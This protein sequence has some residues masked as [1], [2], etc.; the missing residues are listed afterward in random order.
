MKKTVV[1]VI[2]LLAA[3]VAHSQDLL[4][5]LDE[6]SDPPV[7][8]TESTFKSV[9]LVNGYSS[10]VTGKNDLTFSISHRF[11]PVSGGAYEF[12][13][14]DQS[15][16]RLGFEYGLNDRISLG[17]GRSNYEKLF[18]GFVKIK[19]LRQ[20]SGASSFPVSVTLMEGMQYKSLKWARRELDYPETARLSYVHELFIA[21]KFNKWFSAQ[22]VPVIVHRNWV[23]EK[24]EQNIVGAVG[25]GGVFT[26]NKWLGINAEY[27]HLLP[28]HT[29]DNYEN[30]LA[31]GVEIET[32]GGHVF[33]IHLSNS[34]G[35]TEKNFVAETTGSWLDG[36]M[37]LGFNLIRVFN[38]DKKTKKEKEKNRNYE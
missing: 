2:F 10:E 33:Q 5:M 29:A 19:L 6:Q 36:D 8:Y 11:G 25:I 17:I 14:L 23:T 1:F 16:I 34:T 35:M 18:D 27:Y 3:L 21:R 20:K 24:E 28:G 31:L 9:R 37:A 38:L 22:L 13:G 15:T 4:S 12:Y 7:V 26:V 32:G 30:S